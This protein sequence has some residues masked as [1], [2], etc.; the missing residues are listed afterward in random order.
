[1]MRPASKLKRFLFW[2]EG[3]FGG[4]FFDGSSVRD[5]KRRSNKGWLTSPQRKEF[6]EKVLQQLQTMK[7]VK[8]ITVTYKHKG[9]NESGYVM[10]KDITI[11]S[12]D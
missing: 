3:K 12:K 6:E 2:L 5:W 9:D 10:A 11:F 1:M 8:E 4:R 7:D